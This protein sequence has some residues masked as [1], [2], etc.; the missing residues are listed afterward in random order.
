MLSSDEEAALS[1]V[2]QVVEVIRTEGKMADMA[3]VKV[4]LVKA[5]TRITSSAPGIDARVFGFRDARFLVQSC[6]HPG[7]IELIFIETNT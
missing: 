3:R 2:R 7:M 5:G 4:E 6:A 1:L